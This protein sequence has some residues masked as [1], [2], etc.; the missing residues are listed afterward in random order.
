MFRSK[1]AYAV[2]A[3]CAAP[4]ITHASSLVPPVVQP[5]PLTLQI[6]EVATLEYD[7]GSRY[8]IAAPVTVGGQI[9]VADQF[10]GDVYRRNGTGFDRVFDGDITPPDGLELSGTNR[11]INVSRGGTDDTLYVA[12]TV[13]GPDPTDLPD[14]DVRPL[15]SPV[16]EPCC[17]PSRDIDIYRVGTDAE[18]AIGVTSSTDL[19]II[20]RYDL[21]PVTGTLDSSDPTPI[22]ALEVQNGGR[23]HPGGGM[24]T[25]P[26]GRLLFATGDNLPT[27]TNG[28]RAAQD[29]GE[30]VSKLLIIDPEAD[31]DARVTVAAKGLRNTQSLQYTDASQTAVAFGD[32]GGGIAEEINMVGVADLLDTTT[33]ESFGWGEASGGRA[34]EGTFYIGPGAAYGGFGPVALGEAPLSEAGFLQPYAQV[35]REGAP[36]V[37]VTGPVTL[38]T[39]FDT[40]VSVFSDLSLGRLYGTTAPL[41]D[42]NAPVFDVRLIDMDGDL[43]S[44]RELGARNPNVLGRAEPRFFKFADGTAGVLLER[45]GGIYALTQVANVPLPA[46]G[47]L[48]GA[49]ILVFAVSRRRA[50]QTRSADTR[51]QEI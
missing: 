28:R 14:I 23:A 32:I 44:L 29:E 11:I 33:V 36:F 20:Y 6:R 4:A 31:R 27:G 50:T 22:V 41:S 42:I 12:F 49:G 5:S 37:A 48:L 30:H 21:D 18:D 3:C 7:R 35:G 47:L 51:V 38:A 39:S 10:N 16:I 15:P 24:L 17:D 1:F 26:D 45:T 46:S 19:Q 13:R 25:L 9:Y 43:T 8:N 2:A 40:I 34:R